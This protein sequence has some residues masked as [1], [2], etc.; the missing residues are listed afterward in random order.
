MARLGTNSRRIARLTAATL[1]ATVIPAAAVGGTAGV[2]SGAPTIMAAAGT[3]TTFAFVRPRIESGRVRPLGVFKRIDGR[4]FARASGTTDG[5]ARPTVTAPGSDPTIVL[6]ATTLPYPTGTFTAKTFRE[7]VDLSQH[8]GLTLPGRAVI[9]VS[10]DTS[11]AEVEAPLYLQTVTA[12]HSKA[13][14]FPGGTATN[15]AATVYDQYG[16]PVIG[17]P[18]RLTGYANGSRTPVN[19]PIAVTDGGGA[20]TFPGYFGAG[21]YVAYA[22]LNLDGRRGPREPGYQWVV[23]TVA[24]AAPGRALYHNNKR[25][26]AGS[27]TVGDSLRGTRAAAARRYKWIDQNGQL[28][29][30]TAAHRRGGASRVSPAAVTWVNAHGAPYNPRWLKKGRFV[31]RAWSGMRRRPGLRNADMTFQ[32]NAARGVSVEWE[33]K[34]IRPFTSQAALNAAFANLAASARRAYG[35]AWRSRVEVKVLSNLT[36]GQTYALRVLR[37]AHAHGFTTMYLARGK[38]TRAQF[39]AAAHAYVDYVRGAAGGVYAPIP[40]ASQYTAPALKEPPF[41]V[42]G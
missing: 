21:F 4:L 26:R 37:A 22:D 39:P 11:F 35:A 17:A 3:E 7:P 2:A 31:T 30:T 9:R 10:D 40:P 5:T 41:P 15:L 23:G 8:R 29:Y 16:Q 20:A 18:V 38:A 28:T 6:P 42:G 19:V 27:G 24:K 33:V 14:S 12:V 25:T 34:N 32:Q 1:V 36:G 13:A